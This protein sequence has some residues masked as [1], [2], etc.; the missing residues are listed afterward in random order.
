MDNQDL[1][2][3]EPDISQYRRYHPLTPIL[4]SWY[5]LV[6]LAGFYLNSFFDPT[7]KGVIEASWKFFNS[8]S[9]LPYI[10]LGLLLISL[11]QYPLWFI[12]KWAVNEHGVFKREGFISLNRVIAPR[13]R[14]E[15]VSI[16]RNLWARIFGLSSVYI[17]LAGASE[18]HLELEYLSRKDA[19][20]LYQRILELTQETSLEDDKLAARSAEKHDESAINHL[21][22]EGDDTTSS[23]IAKVPIKRLI[24]SML[25]DLSLLIGVFV[26]LVLVAGIIIFNLILTD[27]ILF[28]WPLLIPSFVM[29]AQLLLKKIEQG[30]GFI[31][32]ASAKGLKA[33]R[34]LLSTHSDNISA[35]RIQ[36]ALLK[37]PILW[38]AMN[39]LAITISTSGGEEEKTE[40]SEI[41]PVGDFKDAVFTLE[42]VFPAIGTLAE[43]EL[44][45]PE[46]NLLSDL[47]DEELML[48]ILQSRV[49]NLVGLRAQHWTYPIA[50]RTKRLLFSEKA[51][52]WR[53][54]ILTKKLLVLQREKIQGINFS[55]GPIEKLFNLATITIYTAGENLI[56]E[57]LNAKT[58]LA[59]VDLLSHDAGT[60]RRYSE[61]E[62][63]SLPRLKH[64]GA[65]N[66]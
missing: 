33:R 8:S 7:S 30:W 55:Q 3:I 42:Q 21:V 16:K 37:R 62:N 51:V 5:V 40:S 12:R 14:I 13:E 15:S 49:K 18:S 9:L 26:T 11:W 63:W 61:R 28:S 4:G 65:V 32:R 6:A 66:V 22:Y 45:A 38:T 10:L 48:R 44:M 47:R 41:L 43:T 19:S 57:G 59:V 2:Q 27:T 54:G 64:S 23:L 24:M 50:K 1:K 60:A 46:N 39:W 20:N 52:L 29:L 53:S 58:A 25:L 35:F 36:S 31:S 34:G 56:I 17:E